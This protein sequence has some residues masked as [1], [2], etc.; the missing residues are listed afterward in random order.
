MKTVFYTL[1]SIILLPLALIALVS[2]LAF[3][4]FVY[5]SSHLP[6]PNSLEWKKIPEPKED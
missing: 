3:A 5:V 2:M 6:E 4:R 1:A